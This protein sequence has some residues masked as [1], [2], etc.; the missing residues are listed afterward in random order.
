MN[1]LIIELINK[2]HQ[3]SYGGKKRIHI[4]MRNYENLVFTGIFKYHK[5]R[6]KHKLS[7]CGMK[8]III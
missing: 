1:R 4:N 3:L 6:K 5:R 2:L 8:V 7:L